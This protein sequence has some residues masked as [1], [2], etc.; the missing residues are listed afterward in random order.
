M[1][2]EEYRLVSE[3]LN[4]PVDEDIESFKSAANTENKIIDAY[5]NKYLSL[6]KYLKVNENKFIELE[7]KNIKSIKQIYELLNYEQK[8]RLVRKLKF[9]I[10]P[11]TKIH[12]SLIL[13]R[14]N[15]FIQTYK[16]NFVVNFNA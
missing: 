15:S 2:E 11:S 13:L 10:K 12:M 9:L 14:F 4:R 7:Q 8:M 6:K 16:K 1:E 3:S 5:F